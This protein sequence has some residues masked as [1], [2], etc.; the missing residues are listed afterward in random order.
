M[1]YRNYDHI[2]IIM[3]PHLARKVRLVTLFNV[4]K[5]YIVTLSSATDVWWHYTYMLSWEN[6]NQGHWSGNETNMSHIRP[7]LHYGEGK[8]S[9]N[10]CCL[11]TS[12]TTAWWIQSLSI[13]SAL[14]FIM[15]AFLERGQAH[16]A[17]LSR[18]GSQTH[19]TQQSKYALLHL[20]RVPQKTLNCKCLHIMEMP[21]GPNSVWFREVSLQQSYSQSLVHCDY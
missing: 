3:W 15:L 19:H 4:T 2:I 5:W 6:Q 10:N 21:G 14:L 20:Q 17:S 1:G 12:K 7:L 9:F 18:E 16:H 13:I 11:T 8:L